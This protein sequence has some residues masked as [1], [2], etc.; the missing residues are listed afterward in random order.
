[1]DI[2][3]HSL[4]IVKMKDKMLHMKY[5]VFYINLCVQDNL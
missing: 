4:I 3:S 5:I 2:M 1:M